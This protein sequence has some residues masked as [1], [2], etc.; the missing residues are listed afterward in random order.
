MFVS[1]SGING[2]I[3]NMA[4]IKKSDW[5]KVKSA[6]QKGEGSCRELA[7]RFG[8]SVHAIEKRCEREKW[9]AERAEIVAKVSEKVIEILTNE[10]VEWV[11]RI[12]KSCVKDLDR[13]DESYDQ[14]APAAD[15]LAIKHLTGAKKLSDDVMRRALGLPD[16]PQKHEIQGGITLNLIDPY[17]E[18]DK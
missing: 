6:Y 2:Q 14:M 9:R 4:G 10:S 7:E 3:D 5:L 13:I 1:C 12:K 17:A 8:L 11:Q 16:T 15:P 18:G